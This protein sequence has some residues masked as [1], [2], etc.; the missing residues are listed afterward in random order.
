[1]ISPFLKSPT[2]CL[3]TAKWYLLKHF[4]NGHNPI[5]VI[6]YPRM[7]VCTWRST[8]VSL[9]LVKKSLVLVKNNLERLY[10]WFNLP[11]S[12]T[13]WPF[14]GLYKAPIYVLVPTNSPPRYFLAPYRYLLCFPRST[15]TF[16]DWKKANI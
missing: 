3:S 8:H 10:C 9:H 15:P 7:I 5:K 6:P 14:R 11:F 2:P 16:L 1:M 4:N 13:F 12:T